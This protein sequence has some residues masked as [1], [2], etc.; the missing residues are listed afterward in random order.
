M[1]SWSKYRNIF[2]FKELLGNKII[3]STQIDVCSTYN[4]IYEGV[5]YSNIEENNIM[6]KEHIIISNFNI[7]DNNIKKKQ[8]HFDT[9]T[10][11]KLIFN[12]KQLLLIYSIV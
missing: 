10:Y 8:M 3:Y 4:L 9:S 1:Q 5:K 7:E 11:E 12:K 6:P 2:E